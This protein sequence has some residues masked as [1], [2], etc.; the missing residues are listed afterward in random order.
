MGILKIPTPTSGYNTGFQHR[1]SNKIVGSPS[2]LMK[3]VPLL[4]IPA[5]RLIPDRASMPSKKQCLNM[6][7]TFKQKIE[8]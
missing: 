3:P 5:V 6:N 7:L 2:S 4:K 8:F 1:F